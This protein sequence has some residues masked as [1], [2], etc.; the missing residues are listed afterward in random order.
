MRPIA[1]V[2]TPLKFNEYKFTSIQFPLNLGYLSSYIKPYGFECAL[3]DYAIERYD[4]A[5]F[6][7]RVIE[8]SPPII[9]FHCI[10]PN[11]EAGHAM[12]AIVKKVRPETV[13]IA[14]GP[15]C[16]AL[17]ERT[18]KEFPAF[19]AAVACEG[20]QAFLEICNAVE[21]GLPFT[22]I[23]GAVHRGADGEIISE[24]ARPV[25]ANLDELPFPDRDLRPPRLYS[26]TH[27]TKVV[28]RSRF[29]KVIEIITMRGCPFNCFFCAGHGVF[30]HTTRMR[31]VENVM[32]EIEE[33]RMKYGLDYLLIQDDTFILHRPRVM[34]LCEHFRRLGIG[35]AC[36]ARANLVDTP[37]LDAMARSGCRKVVFGIESG[38]DDML[39]RIEKQTTVEQVKDAIR[40]SRAAGIRTVEG[41]III[42]GH[43]SETTAQ[44]RA[45]LNLVRTLDLDFFNADIIVPYPGS[46]AYSFMKERGL[47][48]SEKWSLY[49]PYGKLPQWRTE[50]F[51]PEDMVN[52]QKLFMLRYYLRPSYFLRQFLRIRNPA[53]LLYFFRMAF[54]YFRREF[55]R[56]P[57]KNNK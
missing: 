14:G 31:S 38:S 34:E 43:P 46:E 20:E 57:E 30:Q 56:P 1:L 21:L 50:N 13:V 8:E 54:D 29:S 52:F 41:T 3:W 9:G 28:P 53:R 25:P 26:G 44:L 10:T 40:M 11:I 42:G 15:H 22:G 19:D 35:W 39:L 47:I 18:L 27:P 12:A 49:V 5:A 17:P 24:P 33:C 2:N 48:L 16:T 4:P 55:L 7:Q 6:A 36:N 37:L 45:T 51:S 23:A 32:A